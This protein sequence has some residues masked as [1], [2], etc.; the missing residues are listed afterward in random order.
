MALVF[1][2]GTLAHESSLGDEER[3]CVKSVLT[4]LGL[5][6]GDV[7]F[8]KKWAT[9]SLFRL[10]AIETLLDDPLR[11]P[12]YVDQL[13]Q[14]VDA[15]HN[16]LTAECCIMAEAVDITNAADTLRILREIVSRSRA[17]PTPDVPGEVANI[18]SVLLASFDVAEQY[19]ERAIEGL[20]GRQLSELLLQ[21]PV[22]WSDEDD[23]TDDHL[24]GALHREYGIEV[25]TSQKVES[26]T[27]LE[28]AR[29]IERDYL[30]LSA[31]TV[32]I[33]VERARQQIS[34]LSRPV[35]EEV[36]TSVVETR[37]GRI[38]VGGL[39]RDEWI[40]D[41]AI[42]VEL[43][44]DDYYAGRIGGAVGVLGSPFSVVID[45]EG[46]DLYTS[47]KL[48]NFGSAIFGCGVLMDLSGHDVYRGSHYCEGVGLF[49]VGYLW[50][51][52]GD[53]IYDG[54]Y[55]VQGGGN[56]GLGGV[57]DCAGND[58]YR[59]YNWAQGVGSVLG[60]GLCADLGGHDIYYAGGRYRH[61]PLLPDD[62]RSFAQG[63]GMGWRP[64]ASG[65]VGLL[66]DKEG[67]DFYC[68]EVYGQGCSYWYS[69]GM[70]VDGSGNDY[71]NAAEYAQGAGIHL[72]VGVL[73]DKDGDDHYFSR[74]GPGQGE[75]HDLSCGILIDKRGDD[76]YTIS[77]GQGI[78]LTNSFGLLVDSEGKD[79]Y[80]TTEELGQG[81]ANQTRGFGGIGIFLDLEGE[82]SY[83]RGTHGE[84]GGFWASGMWGAGM[85]LPRVISREEQL[86]PDTLLETIEDIFEEAALWEVSENKKRVRWARERLVEFCMEAIEYVCEEKIDTKSGLELRAIEELA[87]ALPDSILPSLLDRLQDQRP[88]V[89]ANSIYLLGKT[90]ASEAIP[91]LVEALKKAENKPRWVLSA[92]GDIGTTEPLSDIHP[93]LRSE[94][95][96]A[97]I[98][99][100]AALG[101]IRNPTSIS[102]LVEALGDESF[103]VRTAA[104]NALVA[105]GDSSIQLML[106]GLTDADPPSLVHLIHGLGRIAEELDTLEARTERII[107]KKALLPFLDSDE[108]SLRGYAVEALGRLGG[109]ATRGLLRMRMADELDPYVL[110]KYQ[111]AVD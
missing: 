64:D 85:D 89:R 88:R 16:S 70:L 50:D 79:H 108:V 98:A 83:P 51:G 43:G 19:L 45:C 10:E 41:F 80:A 60:C 81:S 102:Y 109:E 65:G 25:D 36:K 49:G 78:G 97:R 63:F 92:L 61:T 24:K 55:F 93:Y 33:G 57:I 67:N 39:Q 101:K 46:D 54:G 62:H 86:E 48:F 27:I 20:S 22:L 28:F 2:L 40:G 4:A 44:G 100:A 1:A 111:A 8:E 56:F 59:S 53:D 23:P 21:A 38:G 94:D 13:T 37:W 52:G 14:S 95:E 12:D 82:D 26:D 99:A 35:L 71:Y 29:R 105:I 18:L 17:A 106:D 11:A 90:K 15:F 9:D 7:G 30:V 74:Y 66:Y 103:T 58:F 5:S 77:G 96:T 68:A 76:S 42:I 47:T 104:E 91:P 31:I 6:H 73:I 72:S 69:L 3:E 110:G 34:E 107:I 87:L 84:D 75:G 32:L